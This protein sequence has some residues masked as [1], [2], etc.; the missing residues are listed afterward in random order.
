LCAPTE[1]AL[2]TAAEALGPRLG[3]PA[4]AVAIFSEEAIRGSPAAPLSQLIAALQPALR[5]VAGLGAWQVPGS[6]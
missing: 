6:C 5:S 2:Q 4:E 1:G 3:V